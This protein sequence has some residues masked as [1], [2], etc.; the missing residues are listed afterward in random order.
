MRQTWYR[1][2]QLAICLLILLSAVVTILLARGDSA[3]EAIVL[4]WI[5]L[6]GKNVCDYAAS[7]ENAAG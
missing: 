3:W 6:T 1:M 7:L 4:Y 5:V 2:S